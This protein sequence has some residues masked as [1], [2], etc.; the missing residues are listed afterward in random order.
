MT[1]LRN[2]TQLQSLQDAVLDWPSAETMEQYATDVYRI[3]KEWGRR[4]SALVVALREQG[5]T[6][7]LK[8][9]TI[10]RPMD[11]VAVETLRL[12]C[13]IDTPGETSLEFL[14]LVEALAGFVSAG[15]EECLHFRE[16]MES[17]LR[18]LIAYG[19]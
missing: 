19:F 8:D 10:G 3:A 17:V 16:A 1:A 13:R 14:R 6:R 4:F 15:M 5:Y 18:R 7:Q 11:H 9:V 12:A 2:P